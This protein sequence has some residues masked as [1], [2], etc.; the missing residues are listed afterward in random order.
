M[1]ET[2][3]PKLSDIDLK[4][5]SLEKMETALQQAK[6]VLSITH[7]GIEDFSF[8][9]QENSVEGKTGVNDRSILE[10]KK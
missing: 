1:D 4:V 2:P 9:T 6:N 3:D 7:R 8:G 10:V 5:A